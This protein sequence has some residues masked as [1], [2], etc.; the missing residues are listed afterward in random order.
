MSKSMEPPVHERRE[1]NTTAPVYRVAV[2]QMHP[3][4]KQ[5]ASSIQ[6]SLG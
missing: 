6:H 1:T 4:V 3:K 5:Q 2:I